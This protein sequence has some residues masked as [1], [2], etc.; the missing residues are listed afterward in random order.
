MILVQ[1]SIYQ[2]FNLNKI[3]SGLTTTEDQIRLL[4]I[5]DSLIF[6]MD[7]SLFRPSPFFVDPKNG[8][9]RNNKPPAM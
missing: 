6:V 1:E 7:F 4:Q 3:D 9:G 5:C 8:D 2:E